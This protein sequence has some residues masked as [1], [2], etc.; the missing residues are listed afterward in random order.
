[1]FEQYEDDGLRILGFPCNQFADEEP[2]TNEEIKNFCQTNFGVTFDLFS[3]IEVKGPNKPPLYEWLTSVENPWGP[4]K[5]RWNFQKYLI[6]REGTIAA[7]FDPMVEPDHPFLLDCGRGELD[8]ATFNNWLR[9]DYEFVR[10]VLP[11]V[12]TLK[13]KAPAGH[14]RELTEAEVALHEELDLF[15]ERAAVLGVDVDDVPRNLTTHSYVQF[16]FATAYRE[17]Y[18]VAFTAYWTAEK[19]YHESWRVVEPELDEDHP[20]HPLVN[21]WAGEDFAEFVDFLGSTL[22]ELHDQASEEQRRR[23]EEL[24]VWTVRYE[25]AF[26]DMAYGRSG[27]EWIRTYPQGKEQ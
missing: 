23:M 9:Q 25:I 6:D 17:D 11:F 21:N 14:R 12:S 5:V 4:H 27:N 20:W 8:E 19:A 22:H 26:W 24:F 1:M 10:S 16:L 3:K 18:P 7:T 2:G 15:E 13:A